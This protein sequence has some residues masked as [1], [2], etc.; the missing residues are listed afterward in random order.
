MSVAA[1]GEVADLAAAEAARGAA[2]LVDSEAE[3]SGA[4]APEGIGEKTENRE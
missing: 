2:I 1:V 3:A 4:E